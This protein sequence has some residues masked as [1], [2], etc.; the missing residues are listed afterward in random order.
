MVETRMASGEARLR[1][2]RCAISISK[3]LFAPLNVSLTPLSFSSLLPYEVLRNYRIHNA[4]LGNK[5]VTPCMKSGGGV[6]VGPPFRPF[7]ELLHST[8]LRLAAEDRSF[9]P[10]RP[11]QILTS[12]H[13]QPWTS[14]V[15]VH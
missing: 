14:A 10:Q 2:I 7:C 4:V 8:T 15:P 1:E 13:E 9:I 12:P 6:E 11:F 5:A 3:C